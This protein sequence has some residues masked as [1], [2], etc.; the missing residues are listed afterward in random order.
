MRPP[1]PVLAALLALAAACVGATPTPSADG[2]EVVDPAAHVAWARCLVGQHWDGRR[3]AGSPTL[4]RHAEALAR[5]RALARE[6]G[7]RWR[8]PRVPELQHLVRRG[9]EGLDPRLFPGAPADWHWS[10][11]P[12]LER[13]QVNPYNYGSVMRGKTGTEP[14]DSRFMQGWAVHLGDGQARDDVPKTSRLAVRLARD[15]P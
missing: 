8:V 10:S 2:R 15:Y 11:T 12:S 3:C 4:L 13:E 9:G 5:A 6:T 7:Q 14:P 1:L